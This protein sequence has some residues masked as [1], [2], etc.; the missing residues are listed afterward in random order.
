MTTLVV[1]NNRVAWTYTDD[2]GVDYR[3]SAKSVY[4]NHATDGGKYGGALADSTVPALPKGFKM[5][6]V[7]LTSAT[8][9]DLWVVV[10]ET[11]ATAWTTGG[12]T[13]TRNLN[14]VDVV[15]TVTVDGRR[16][17]KHPRSGITQQA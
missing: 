15:Y 17:E 16:S 1:D 11:T 6:K 3:V 12:T 10:Y 2:L 7:K 5:R 8:H 14:G 9:P 13:L 4:V